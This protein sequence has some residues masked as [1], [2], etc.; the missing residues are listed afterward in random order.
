MLIWN[1]IINALADAAGAVVSAPSEPLE[2]TIIPLDDY[3]FIRL[4]GPDAV[5]FLQG[6]STCD[7]MRLA[8]HDVLLGAHCNPKGRMISSFILSGSDG[9]ILLRLHS[10]LLELGFEALKKYSVFSKVQLQVAENIKAF[11]VVGAAAQ[12]EIS[13]ALNVELAAGKFLQFARCTL[14]VLHEYV[15]EF[16]GEQ[17]DLLAVLAG[18]AALPGLS[19]RR[20]WDKVLVER[21]WA[22]VQAVTTENYIPQMFNYHLIDGISFK[23]G[24]YTGQ[25]IVARMQYL[26][27]QKKH[28]YLAYAATGSAL[29]NLGGALRVLGKSESQGEIVGFAARDGVVEFLAVI[30]DE[31]AN[32][33]DI[34][35]EQFPEAKISWL[36]LPY[37]IP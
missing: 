3:G 36:E 6:Q 11:A 22:E 20:D 30:N 29:L 32:S 19:A 4:S 21:G 7:C 12:A 18:I 13:R 16:R 24:C 17:D 23:K 14:L 5:K 28:L 34:Y 25:E 26:G 10:S 2:L 33:T 8:N 15:V 27:K 31:A 9:D 35:I 1:S 37:A